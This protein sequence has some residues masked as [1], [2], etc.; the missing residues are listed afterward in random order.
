MFV[1]GVYG[2]MLM[3]L[4]VC[5]VVVDNVDVLV[6]CCCCLCLLLMLAMVL[7]L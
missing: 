1:V 5:L 4:F 2:G 3:V 7:V 6:R